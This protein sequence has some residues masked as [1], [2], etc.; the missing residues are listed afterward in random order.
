MANAMGN[1][2][3]HPPVTGS[4]VMS[5][6]P[7]Q[8]LGVMVTSATAGATMAIYDSATAAN[9][10]PIYAVFD[11]TAGQ[12]VSLPVSTSEGLYIVVTG[13]VT[14]TAIFA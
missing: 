3:Y 12:L 14:Y 2:C 8:C 10:N 9:V 11:V 13:T 6:R 4:A 1:S 7:V 5:V